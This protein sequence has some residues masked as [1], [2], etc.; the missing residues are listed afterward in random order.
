MVTMLQGLA[1]WLR[2]RRRAAHSWADDCDLI[3]LD[4]DGVLN[5]RVSRDTGDHLPADEPLA[6]LC[7]VINSSCK[8]TIVLSSTWRLDRQ[9]SEALQKVLATVGLCFVSSTADLTYTGDRVDEILLW[10]RE[11]PARGSGAA[12]AWVALDDL[13]LLGMNAKL[14]PEHF[15]RT[16]D[17]I[18]LTRQDA[19]RAIAQLRSQRGTLHGKPSNDG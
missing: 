18:G 9:L 6:N 17:G 11:H 10:L 7:H 14:T 3:F 16:R 19:E 1:D 4:V 5:S 13:D 2:R 15:V 8:A 12:R